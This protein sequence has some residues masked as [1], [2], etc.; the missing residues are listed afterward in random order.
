MG[1]R[2]FFGI[3]VM[4]F[5]ATGAILAHANSTRSSPFSEVGRARPE[6]YASTLRINGN[7]AAENISLLA[8]TL[9]GH[10][11]QRKNAACTVCGINGATSI[12]V[13]HKTRTVLLNCSGMKPGPTQLV[14]ETHAEPVSPG[15]WEVEFGIGYHTSVREECPHQFFSSNQRTPQPAY[16]IGPISIDGEIPSD[17]NMQA[18]VCV[19]L[20][21]AREGGAGKETGAAL[22]I[23]KLQ[24]VSQ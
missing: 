18:L 11:L 19:G 20:S 5:C 6:A 1:I 4:S 15:L 22:K 17:G 23:S 2:Q 12:S 10:C 24:I 14:M 7:F 8:G 16:E 3:L 21:S 13:N 9:S